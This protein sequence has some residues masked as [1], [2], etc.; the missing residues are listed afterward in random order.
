MSEDVRRVL[1]PQKK[2]APPT[3]KRPLEGSVPE[4]WS[5]TDVQRLKEAQ[6]AVDPLAPNY[7]NIVGAKV[8]KSKAECLEFM[9]S[10]FSTP[11]KRPRRLNAKAEFS[12]FG[13]LVL[14]SG[15]SR[16]KVIASMSLM[17][18]QTHRDDPFQ[19]AKTVGVPAAF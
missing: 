16:P 8:G 1:F 17:E 2:P 15:S 18:R 9:E 6:R 7:W 5:S 14:K 19:R 13:R 4:G 10:S 11:E 3:R 12:S